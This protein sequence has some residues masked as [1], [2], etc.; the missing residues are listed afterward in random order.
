MR[1]EARTAQKAK[2]HLEVY[3]DLNSPKHTAMV[4]VDIIEATYTHGDAGKKMELM[5]VNALGSR[6]SGKRDMTTEKAG[7]L[8]G[9][10][11]T[12]R[13]KRIADIPPHY[14][15]A[16]MTPAVGARGDKDQTAEVPMD[17]HLVM[18]VRKAEPE[19]RTM[20]NITVTARINHDVGPKSVRE[21]EEKMNEKTTA[22]TAWDDPLPYITT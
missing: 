11:R 22:M 19:A 9:R 15:R 14:M 7:P 2:R 20:F 6:V 3:A 1:A 12:A 13:V 4:A 8:E 17:A 21:K 5:T 18:E 10:C 16:V